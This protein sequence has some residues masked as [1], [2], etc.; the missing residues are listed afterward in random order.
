[1]EKL[2]EEREV[3]RKC[4]ETKYHLQDFLKGWSWPSLWF[5]LPCE[6]RTSFLAMSFLFHY[7]LLPCVLSLAEANP[8]PSVWRRQTLEPA[9]ALR[10]LMHLGDHINGGESCASR[11]QAMKCTHTMLRFQRK[12]RIARIG[13]WQR[14]Q[15][16]V[17][18][19]CVTQT[20]ILLDCIVLK[21]W[22]ILDTCADFTFVVFKY[23][24]VAMLSL[25]FNVGRH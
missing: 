11:N 8:D 7:L 19:L 25:H 17:T 13:L 12:A 6:G 18:E 2:W 23:E 1:M 20:C 9:G 3:E 5:S 15:R 4:S 14:L 10:I 16:T 22:E 21:N 24:A